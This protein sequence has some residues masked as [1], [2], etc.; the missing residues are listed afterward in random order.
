MLRLVGKILK[1]NEQIQDAIDNQIAVNVWQNGSYI[2]Q[3]GLIQ[4]QTDD[5]VVIDG[6]F[7]LK[8][9]CEFRTR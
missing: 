3:G 9:T 4:R 5:V 1:T 8:A 2:D 7:F 6:D